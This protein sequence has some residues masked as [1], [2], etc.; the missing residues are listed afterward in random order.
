MMPH[1]VLFEK[2]KL[3][4]GDAQ[5]LEEAFQARLD[6]LGVNGDGAGPTEER[7]LAHL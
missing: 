3:M 5:V 2:N 4:A 6:A 7:S 1:K